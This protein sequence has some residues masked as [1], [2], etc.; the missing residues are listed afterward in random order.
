MAQD[1]VIFLWGEFCFSNAGNYLNTILG[2]ETSFWVTQMSGSR[3][4]VHV[5][6]I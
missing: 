6:A 4:A 3:I 1:D 5:W 2:F